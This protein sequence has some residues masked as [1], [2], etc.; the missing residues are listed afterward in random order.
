LKPEKVFKRYDIRGRY[1]EEINEEFAEKLGRA[2]GSFTARNYGNKIVVGRDNKDTS[3]KLK[4]G[5]IQGL[6]STGMKVIY[7]G[8]GPTDYTTF[9]GTRED[10]VSIQITSSHMPLDFNGFKLM[11]PEGNSFVNE[12]LSGIKDIFREEDFIKGTGSL[13]NRESVFRKDYTEEVIRFG[14]RTGEGFS[15]KKIV[16]DSLGGAG[17]DLLPEILR[18]LGAEVIDLSSEK[19]KH[20]Y[21]DPPNPKPESL[22]ELKKRV[23]EENADMGIALDMDA[24]RVKIY[25]NGFVSGSDL[26]GVFS[27]L[28]DS[29]LVASVDTSKKVE[30]I[31]SSNGDEV[32]YTRV[33]DPFVLEKAVDE[34][35]DLAGEPNGHYAFLDFVP[36]S[37]GILSG[38]IAAGLDLDKYMENLSEYQAVRSNVEVQDKHE[39]MKNVIEKVRERF[40]VVSEIDGIKFNSDDVTVLVRS[41]GSSPKIRIISE[42]KNLENAEEVLIEVEKLIQNA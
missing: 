27:Q 14:N 33:G 19:E 36:Y 15:E 21:R 35:V 25:R 37:S 24:D 17:K 20:P 16:V 26:F 11:Y 40:D 41:S 4:E 9:S 3:N 34:E 2:V 42:S 39:K 23:G 13:D 28:F 32:L 1:P 30:E 6:K 31:N 22:G 38:V 29:D 5:L 8:V 7:A 12:D 18:E 10:S